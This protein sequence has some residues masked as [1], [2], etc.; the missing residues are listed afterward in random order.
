MQGSFI[1]VVNSEAEKSGGGVYG[2]YFDPE[3]NVLDY[4]QLLAKTTRNCGGGESPW[5]TF[6]SCEE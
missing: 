2:I 6:I 3:G 4:K 1:Y 5:N